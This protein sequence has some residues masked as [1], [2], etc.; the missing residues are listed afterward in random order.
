MLVL[1]GHTAAVR[2]LAFAP[3]GRILASGGDDLTVRLWDLH[4]RAE[5]ACCW[6]GSH[7]QSLAF[8]QAGKVLVSAGMAA[9]VMVR[10]VSTSNPFVAADSGVTDI[11]VRVTDEKRRF[12]TAPDLKWQQG[13]APPAAKVIMLD[14][15][16]KYQ[17][18]L[19]FGAAFTDASCY[20]FNQ[21]SEDA[22]KQLFR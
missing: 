21:L 19:G 3:D 1:H 18:I 22:R 12:Q 8:A 6:Q 2:C 10:S 7:V 5:L 4:T 20:V 11:K 9:S 17:E 13:S 14:P 16:I 15:A